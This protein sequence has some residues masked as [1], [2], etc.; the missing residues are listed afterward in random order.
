MRSRFNVEVAS[1]V[2]IRTYDKQA[3]HS[4]NDR[5]EDEARSASREIETTAKRAYLSLKVLQ[6]HQVARAPDK[7]K[8]KNWAEQRI[9]SCP[10]GFHCTV[11][12]VGPASEANM[13]QH[14][15]SAQHRKRL[16][17]GGIVKDDHILPPVPKEYQ[18]RGIIIK[19]CQDTLQYMCKLC[20]AGPFP[21]LDSV[22]GHLRGAKHSQKEGR[23]PELQLTA[24]LRKEGF[25]Q[26]ADQ[27][28][29]Q[30]CGAGPFSDRQGLRLHRQTLQ[31]REGETQVEMEEQLKHLPGYC[32]L[33][34]QHFC[35][36]MCNISAGSL[37]DG[38]VQHLV[39]KGHRKACKCFSEP[40]PVIFCKDLIVGEATRCYPLQG[41]LRDG[42]LEPIWRRKEEHWVQAGPGAKPE[43]AAPPTAQ[44]MPRTMVVKEDV[45]AAAADHL[46]ASMGEK[47]K[48]LETDQ[49]WAWA[50]SE[51]KSGWI[52][53]A[54]LVKKLPPWKL[55][56]VKARAPAPVSHAREQSGERMPALAWL[57][58][59]GSAE[60]AVQHLAAEGEKVV[61]EIENA[62]QQAASKA[63]QL[64]EQGTR[65][66]DEGLKDASVAA[67]E[68]AVSVVKGMIKPNTLTTTIR[69]M[70]VP[71]APPAV[72]W[73]S[74]VSPAVDMLTRSLLYWLM[75]V[76]TDLL[77]LS[78]AF[79][80]FELVM[81]FG[82]RRSEYLRGDSS[83][84][85]AFRS[86]CTEVCSGWVWGASLLAAFW[87]AGI[88]LAKELRPFAQHLQA[89]PLHPAAPY[90]L[91]AVCAALIFGG[92]V[93][94]QDQLP[95]SRG[96][97]SEKAALEASEK[98]AE[99]SGN[100]ESV[101]PAQSRCWRA[102]MPSEATRSRAF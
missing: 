88:L 68:G 100:K 80:A 11:C 56:K 46:S 8:L 74:L 58:E 77:V 73:R 15:E 98:L 33:I 20:N 53:K 81:G 64:L 78:L 16:V 42:D 34:G 27:L 90:L 66:A 1:I 99:E 96:G 69:P 13:Q 87:V 7:A 25:I 101:P 82:R 43:G 47:I 84:L 89:A 24:E 83:V 30:R 59:V 86:L 6:A 40:E 63:G 10:E 36:Y 54:A 12:K 95:A 14:V 39:G 51:S 70:K 102:R 26:Q 18:A 29:C 71:P 4:A 49:Q 23:E 85:Q 2:D 91:G 60:G 45:V 92:S 5:C 28:L 75:P 79:V 61:G 32:H 9:R 97:P 22:E 72:D 67:R 21:K 93:I 55:D 50:E 94:C 76:V 37:E 19:R 62:T 31:H 65:E 41:R 3:T 35:C 17:L 57:A 48:V 38:I 44:P 52:L